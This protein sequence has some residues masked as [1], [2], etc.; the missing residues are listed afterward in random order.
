MCLSFHFPVP[1]CPITY[2]RTW[3]IFLSFF[4][5]GLRRHWLSHYRR[6]EFSRQDIK[7]QWWIQPDWYLNMKTVNKSNW[8]KPCSYW[9]LAAKPIINFNPSIYKAGFHCVC[10][11]SVGRNGVTIPGFPQL[12]HLITR[13]SIVQVF[14][15]SFCSMFR[16][17]VS[18]TLHLN[19]K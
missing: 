14:R 15:H 17:L 8:N 1:C 3:N 16:H 6:G 11:D 7:Q 9:H 19:M 4:V 5:A 18:T 10:G 12:Q 13:V 2:Q